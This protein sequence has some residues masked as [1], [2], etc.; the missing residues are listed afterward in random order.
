MRAAHLAHLAG[1][2]RFAHRVLRD[3]GVRHVLSTHRQFHR[4]D[5]EAMTVLVELEPATALRVLRKTRAPGVGSDDDERLPER[6]RYLA[7]AYELLGREAR[8][9]RLS[10]P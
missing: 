8:A 9:S 1:V 7:R 2:H 5:R 3:V 4:L 6:R 10:G